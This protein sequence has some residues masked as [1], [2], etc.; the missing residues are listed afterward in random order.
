MKYAWLECW[1]EMSLFIQSID[2][3]MFIQQIIHDAILWIF[4]LLSGKF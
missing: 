1:G 4:A 3:Q 2:L